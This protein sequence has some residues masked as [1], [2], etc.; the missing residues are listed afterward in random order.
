MRVNMSMKV[1]TVLWLI[2]MVGVISL[3]WMNLPIPESEELQMPLWGIKLLSLI[4][5]TF[6]LSVAVLVG[7]TL[8]HKV[9]LSAPLA[10]AIVNGTSMR[11]AIQPQLLSGIIGG[12]VGGIMVT[13]IQVCAKFVLPPD[14]VMKAEELSAGTPLFVRVLY[15]GIAEELILRWGM[16]TLLVWLGW[17][18]V[19]QGQGEPSALCFV[20]G[21][22]LSAF[23]FGLAHLP[24]VFALE[25][26]VTV[27]LITYVIV[28]NSVFGLIAGYLYWRKGLEA[29][30]ISHMLVHVVMLAAPSLRS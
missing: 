17:R 10:E 13:A 18:V 9:G 21:I 8:A 6:L 19:S 1:F 16:M 2:G 12:L 26:Q 15:G 23:L 27:S 29:A 25:T 24:L 30:M 7:V 20:V 5:P 4:Q 22:A 28:G 14:F 3:W 11:L